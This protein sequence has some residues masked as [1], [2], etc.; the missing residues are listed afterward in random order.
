MTAMHA[1]AGRLARALLLLLLP[2][3]GRVQLPP[4]G[5]WRLDRPAPAGGEVPR[6]GVLRVHDLQL[7]NALHGDR[8]LVAL[9]PARVEPRPTDHWIAPLDHLVTDAVVIGL[10]RTRMFSL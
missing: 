9:G 2:A 1:S 10:S 7:A 8:L 5:Y 4:E 3:C 6:G